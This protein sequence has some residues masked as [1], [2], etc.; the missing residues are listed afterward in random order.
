M[1]N[2]IIDGYRLKKNGSEIQKEYR[3]RIV[4]DPVISYL[5]RS[6]LLE[7]ERKTKKTQRG[8]KEWNA[9]NVHIIGKVE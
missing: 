3:L 6:E 1:I 2:C 5:R 9:I 4:D 8:V 7:C